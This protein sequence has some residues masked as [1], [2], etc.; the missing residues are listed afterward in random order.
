MKIFKG[1]LSSIREDRNLLIATMGYSVRKLCCGREGGEDGV[2]HVTSN[3]KHSRCVLCWTEKVTDYMVLL[4]FM[5]L[6]I[7]MYT[8][9][10]LRAKCSI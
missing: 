1:I 2:E 10:I 9:T 3:G 7:L 8:K 4:C 6:T 5:A